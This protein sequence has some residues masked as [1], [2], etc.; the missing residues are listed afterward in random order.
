MWKI[1]LSPCFNTQP[2][3]GGCTEFFHVKIQGT[4]STHSRPK[5]AA[6]GNATQKNKRLTFQ[7][8]AARRRLPKTIK[9]KLSPIIVSTHRRPK[10]AAH[11]IK[12]TKL[13]FKTV[14]THSRPKAAAAIPKMFRWDT[15]GFNT[16]P[17]EGGCINPKQVPWRIVVSTHSRPKAAATKIDS[18]FSAK[19]VSTHSRPKAAAFSY[20]TALSNSISFNTQPPEG[21]CILVAMPPIIKNGFNTQPPEG[22]CSLHKKVRKIS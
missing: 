18:H 12:I 8:T 11:K 17:P 9:G 10:A 19:V 7:H 15:H 20:V 13:T 3:E 14:S 1:F 16:Q 6:V 5:A 4:V 21:G 22:G 2:P